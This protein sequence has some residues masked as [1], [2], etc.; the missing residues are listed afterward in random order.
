MKI[1]IYCDGGC[2]GNGNKDNIGA[3]AYIV[4]IDGK[5]TKRESGTIKKTTSNRMELNA[6]IYALESISNYNDLVTIFSD[7]KY[8]VDG[9]TQ[10]INKWIKNGW[11]TSEGEPVKNDDLW[12]CLMELKN[13]F[14]DIKFKWIQGHAD[15][16]YNITVD[17]MV[18]KKMDIEWNNTSHDDL[19]DYR[20]RMEII[21]YDNKIY[22]KKEQDKPWIKIWLTDDRKDIIGITDED[23]NQIND[24]DQLDGISYYFKQYVNIL[25]FKNK[26]E[27][28]ENKT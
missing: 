2:I 23:N 8:L 15:N 16:L 25:E 5:E 27:Q 1:D 28:K 13:K 19:D 26:Y 24:Y 3:W 17:E 18:N 22:R 21:S 9:I 4:I 6:C 7:S 11:I 10:W 20:H 14:N 12:K